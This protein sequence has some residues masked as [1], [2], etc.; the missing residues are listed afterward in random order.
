MKEYYCVVTFE[1]TQHALIFEK[2][3]KENKLGVKLMP[4]P[5]VLSSSCGTAAYVTCE[6]KVKILEVC[7]A[8]EIPIE[9]FHELEVEKKGSWFLKHINKEKK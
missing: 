8:H 4:V 1:I 3:L 5:R 7:K 9:E 2:H 6:E